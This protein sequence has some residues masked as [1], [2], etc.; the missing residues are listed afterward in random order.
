MYEGRWNEKM[1]K[2][3][4]RKREGRKPWRLADM[5]I[6]FGKIQES[7]I[8]CMASQCLSLSWRWKLLVRA[9][10]HA[11]EENTSFRSC[12]FKDFILVPVLFSSA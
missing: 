8:L 3:C 2:V 7:T 4:V 6:S 5:G 11:S 12:Y 10:V 1:K 9:S